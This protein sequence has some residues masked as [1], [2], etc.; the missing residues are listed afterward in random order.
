MQVYTKGMG[1]G[2]YM[3]LLL[4]AYTK[5]WQGHVMHTSTYQRVVIF[6]W[7]FFLTAGN[8]ASEA[9][10]KQHSVLGRDLVVLQNPDQ[11]HCI[12]LL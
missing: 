8:Q 3:H 1:L 5:P 10:Q 2:I 11:P 6:P 4:A 12:R 9:R 7:R